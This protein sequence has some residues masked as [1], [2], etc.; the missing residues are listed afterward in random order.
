MPRTPA[1]VTANGSATRATSVYDQLR[2]EV[3]GG[4]LE[5]GTKL[6]IQALALACDTRATPLREA[7]NRQ[8]ADGL[9]QRRKRRGFVVAPISADDR[10]E[11]TRTRFWLEE[12]ALRESIKARGKAWEEARVSAH[13]RLSRTPRSWVSDRFEDNPEW[14][15]FTARS[16]GARS[17][18]STYS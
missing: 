13:H 15:R 12:M 5:P 1:L 10:A 6:A 11:I 16:P 8:V 18:T 2:A 3:L 7:L 9:V 17:R 14:A 4:V